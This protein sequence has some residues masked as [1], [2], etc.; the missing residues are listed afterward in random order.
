MWYEYPISHGYIT[1]HL[2]SDWDS[3]HYA[4]DIATPIDTPI[5]AFKSG[6]VVQ[7][8]YAVWGGKQG[9]GEVW[10]Q[11]DDGSPEYYFYHLD[12][13]QVKAGQHV[14]Q[15]QQVGLSG[16]QNTGGQHPTDPSWS[17]G[18]HLHVGYFTSFQ[19]TA[20]GTR[21]YGPD[22]TP[23]INQ[24]KIGG[25]LPETPS[26]QNVS[27]FDWMSI[28]KSSGIL[29]FGIVILVIGGMFLIGGKYVHSSK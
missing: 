25:M 20:I 2:E 11:P 27:T 6:K 1:S 26:S 21:P 16:G 5:T 19:N 22:I 12:L 13:N 3:P 14:S 10:I 24:L 17:S 8:D 29:L 28:A 7:A 9:G 4:D 23:T 15:G 18:P